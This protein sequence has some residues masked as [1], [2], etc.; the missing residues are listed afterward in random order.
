M[1]SRDE[2][3]GRALTS[4]VAAGTVG[5][6]RCDVAADRWWWSD[7]VYRMHGYEPGEVT[8]TTALVL[9]HLRPDEHPRQ[10]PADLPEGTFALIRRIHDTAGR[11]HVLA[12]IAEVHG[13]EVTGHVVDVTGPTGEL[14]AREAARQFRRAEERRAVIDEAI[15][16]IAART[17]LTPD[18][19]FAQ[20]RAAS[21]HDNVKLR[22]VALQVVAAVAPH[23]AAAPVSPSGSWTRSL[24]GLLPTTGPGA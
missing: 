14:A 6:F 20:L 11:E 10:T 2:D 23:G 18:E 12:I 8:P 3:V 15:G 16:I 13:P 17:G 19:A 22:D 5:T 24:V 21:M 4:G 1:A 7:E 9:E